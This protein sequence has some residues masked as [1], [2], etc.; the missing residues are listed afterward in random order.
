MSN[1]SIPTT[2]AAPDP[3][4]YSDLL[5]RHRRNDRFVFFIME[6]V[7]LQMTLGK[8]CSVPTAQEGDSFTYTITLTNTGTGAVR[9]VTLRDQVSE[10]VVPQ[11]SGQ[12]QQVDDQTV[13]I[14]GITIQPGTSQ[15]WDLSA[16]AF[17]EGSAT[18]TISVIAN[19]GSILATTTLENAPIILAPPVVP[20]LQFVQSNAA[21]ITFDIINPSNRPASNVRVEHRSQ[22]RSLVGPSAVSNDLQF[23][24]VI[25]ASAPGL[26]IAASIEP[27]T[28]SGGAFATPK[29]SYFVKIASLPAGFVRVKASLPPNLKT[30]RYGTELRLL[31][32]AG[33]ALG[34]PVRSEF[35]IGQVVAAQLELLLLSPDSTTLGTSTPTPYDL[36]VELKRSATDPGN[37]LPA[38]KLNVAFW[39]PAGTVIPSANIPQPA[40]LSLST[41][42]R[43][44]YLGRIGA[45]PTSDHYLATFVLEQS[46][47]A[48]QGSAIA[49]VNLTAILPGHDFSTYFI[50]AW[51]EGEI[52]NLPARRWQSP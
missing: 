36:R 10:H 25:A 28:G 20:L 18:N 41:G 2:A 17:F 21:H 48:P 29:T 3:F 30:A 27:P 16:T 52:T 42:S 46:T 22:H 31:D 12:W 15:S 44:M 35:N 14:R 40:E 5:P 9:N 26:G 23:V 37:N 11:E 7:P 49:R 24:S 51:V 8:S 1:V 39:V 47:L 33:A 34:T 38:L 50:D 6:T 32:S 45:A 4:G 19:D 43:S 13:E